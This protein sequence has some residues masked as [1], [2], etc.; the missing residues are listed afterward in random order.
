V[1]KFFRKIR[2]KLLSENPPAGRAG[3]FSKYLIYAIGEIILVV[4]GILIALSINNWNNDKVRANQEVSLLQD[5]IVDLKQ[6]IN[7]SNDVLDI[8]TEALKKNI[9]LR[10]VLLKKNN[11]ADNLPLLIRSLTFSATPTFSTST[12][13]T[14][15]QTGLNI[16]SSDTLRKSIL[17]FY[18]V[19]LP[20]VNYKS[21]GDPKNQFQELLKPYFNK[22]FKIE[23]NSNDSITRTI[24][25][26]ENMYNDNEFLN[27]LHTTVIKR[28]KLIQHLNTGKRNS[29]FLIKEIEKHLS[30]KR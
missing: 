29:D 5:M 1:I 19:I 14:I 13:K 23:L 3:K 27:E 12:Y 4:I 30:E 25:N 21:N 16:I 26:S 2:Q 24:C 8:H 7:V 11:D 20:Y 10:E 9:T 28:K 17:R 6:N 15:S 18:E 22:Y